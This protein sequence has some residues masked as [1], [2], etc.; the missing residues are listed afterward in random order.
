MKIL[1]RTVTVILLS[2]FFIGLCVLL[3]PAISQYWNSR[4]QS[5]AVTAYADLTDTLTDYTPYFEA[6]E[7][8][9]RRLAAMAVPLAQYSAVEGYRDTLSVTA[10]GIMGYVTIEKIRVELPIYHGT[11][12]S[13][14]NSACGHLEGS[15]LPVG[16]KGTHCV[17]S[18]HRGL[19]SAAL[20]KDLNKLEIGDVFTLTILGKVLTY[21]VDKITEV[22]PDQIGELRIFDGED[23]CTLLTCTPYGINTR[24]LLVRGTRI[25]NIK[26][27][28]RFITAEAYIID[29]LIVAP[30]V[31][32]PILLSLVMIVFFKPAKKKPA[33][34][35]NEGKR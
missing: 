34:R 14:L 15:S 6:A 29:R 22:N 11:S 33:V 2:V 32:L 24:R 31:A 7:D 26:V 13:V 4:V 27:A 30:A 10:D 19:P 5:R 3:Y 16:G 23:Y 9:N 21:Q 18:A 17:L 28:K 20:F 35:K 1:G 12:D 8:Y 25:E